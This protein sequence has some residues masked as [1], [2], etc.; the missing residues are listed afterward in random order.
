[1][2]CYLICIL[3]NLIAHFSHKMYAPLKSAKGKK[4][5]SINQ[6]SQSQPF[7]IKEMKENAPFWKHK[8]EIKF[9]VLQIKYL[10]LTIVW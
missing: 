4:R 7:I 6:M 3:L 5:P 8:A 2:C 1:M 10:L 9:Y